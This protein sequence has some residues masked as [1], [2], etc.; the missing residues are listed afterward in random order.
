[1]KDLGRRLRE[2]RES[3]GLSIYDVER[4]AQLHFSTISK[5]ER[6]ERQPSIEVLRELAKVYG[7]PLA[8]LFA[9]GDDLR[10]FLPPEQIEWLEWLRARPQLAE[11]LA[12]AR[13][14][15]RDRLEALIRF[16]R[17]DPAV[18]A[19]RPYPPPPRRKD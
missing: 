7:V 8:S 9:E 17:T 11:L 14:L 19:V 12:L 16:L 6:N 18:T 5:Y 13:H 1:M 3:R 4:R 10:Q 15:P 2:L